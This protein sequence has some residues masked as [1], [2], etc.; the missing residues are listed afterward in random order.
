MLFS[1]ENTDLG[2]FLFEKFHKLGE[3]VRRSHFLLHTYL[4]PPLSVTYLS[5]FHCRLY[6]MSDFSVWK[7][8]ILSYNIPHRRFTDPNSLVVSDSVLIPQMNNNWVLVIPVNS[9]GTKGNHWKSFPLFFNWVLKLLP[10]SST[11]WRNILTKRLKQIH[12]L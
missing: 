2:Q 11:L 4:F 12:F 3:F 1:I 5:R 8:N 10:V 6:W 7:E 9:S